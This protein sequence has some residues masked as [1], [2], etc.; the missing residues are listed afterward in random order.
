[1]T[2]QTQNPVIPWLS[3][4]R[5][6]IAQSVLRNR[7]EELGQTLD[8][9]ASQHHLHIIRLPFTPSLELTASR[10]SVYCPLASEMLNRRAEQKGH[11]GLTLNLSGKP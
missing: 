10:S 8:S 2:C 6:T 9:A 11:S 3:H 1:V 5:T 4:L 7:L